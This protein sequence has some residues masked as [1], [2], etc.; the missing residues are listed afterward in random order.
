GVKEVGRRAAGRVKRV[1]GGGT[2]LQ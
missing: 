1:L 2:G